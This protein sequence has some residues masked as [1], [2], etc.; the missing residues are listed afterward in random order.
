LGFVQAGKRAIR[1]GMQ[2][3]INLKVYSS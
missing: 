3:E 2:I 1:T